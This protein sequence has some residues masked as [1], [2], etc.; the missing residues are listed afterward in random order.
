VSGHRGFP[1]NPDVITVY[2]GQFTWEHA[3]RIAGELERAGIVWWFKEPGAISRIWE[4]DIRLFVDRS[5][6]DEAR[7]IAARILGTCS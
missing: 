6:I 5:R 1:R 3:D 4:R 2:L 7:G